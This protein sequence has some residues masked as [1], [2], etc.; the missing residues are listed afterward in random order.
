MFII[1]SPKRS[2]KT[3]AECSLTQCIINNLSLNYK[4]TTYYITMEQYDHGIG[5]NG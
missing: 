5:Y 4:T 3:M 2:D 1:Q